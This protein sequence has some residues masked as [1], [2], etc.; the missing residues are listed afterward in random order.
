[1]P[2]NTTRPTA[3]SVEEKHIFIFSRCCYALE[4]IITLCERYAGWRICGTPGTI[5]ELKSMLLKHP[6]DLVIIDT[7]KADN[8]LHALLCLPEFIQGRRLLLCEDRTLSFRE[9]WLAAGYDTVVSKNIRVHLLDTLLRNLVNAGRSERAAV[10]NRHLFP[11]KEKKVLLRLLQ[12]MLLKDIAKE[13]GI[14]DSTACR[15][16]KRCL[17]RAGVN[18]L[19]GILLNLHDITRVNE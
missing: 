17:Q 9:T 4:G 8:D 11:P 16:K 18:N 10:F 6:V 1:M 19:N 7:Q 15:L 3:L 13:L 5:P 12:G 2:L 14:S